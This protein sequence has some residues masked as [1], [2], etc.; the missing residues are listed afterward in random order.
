M[1]SL[2]NNRVS[3]EMLLK[4]LQTLRHAQRI[5]SFLC[6]VSLLQPFSVFAQTQL[7]RTSAKD[8]LVT[9]IKQWVSGQLDVSPDSVKVLASD[10]RLIVRRCNEDLD[11]SF[12][13]GG[14]DT[15]STR[16]RMPEWSLTLRIEILA[17]TKAYA[18]LKDLPIGAKISGS[19]IGLVVTEVI[20]SD[21]LEI[22]DI[23]GQRLNTAVV[24]NQVVRA[25]MLDESVL[26]FKLTMDLDKN[27]IIDST[28]FDSLETIRKNMPSR[29]ILKRSEVVG[30]KT[31]K[32]LQAGQI[33]SRADILTPQLGLFTTTLVARG[34]M[35]SEKYY[36]LKTHFGSLPTDAIR[37]TER[38]GR[39]SVIRQLEPDQIIRYSDIR[40]LADVSKGDIVKLTVRRGSITVSLDMLATEQGYAGDRIMLE[41][42][43]SGSIVDALITGPGNAE[44]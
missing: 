35:L 38:L 37:S 43:Q 2:S 23:I 9:S 24:A 20:N 11:L 25:S 5:T 8:S 34:T 6:C 17:K 1:Y 42:L 21:A 33:L 40:P 14:S 3:S 39:A 22:S 15:V 4:Y 16:C 26:Q 30:A 12:V 41:N 7:D 13:F 10:P 31:A 18:F 29:Q 27:V 28:M 19:D 32:K 36:E 44:R